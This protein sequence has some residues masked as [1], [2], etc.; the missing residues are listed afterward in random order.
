VLVL[1]VLQ[2]ACQLFILLINMGI[3]IFVQLLIV[4]M[5]MMMFVFLTIELSF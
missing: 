3:F 4:K 1:D 2:T 5:T